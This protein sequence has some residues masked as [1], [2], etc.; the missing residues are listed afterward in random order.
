MHSKSHKGN[1]SFLSGADYFSLQCC[2]NCVCSIGALKGICLLRGASA[3]SSCILASHKP[4]C[5]NCSM[6]PAAPPWQR[7]QK[8]LGTSLFLFFPPTT[9]PR[10]DTPSWDFLI[11]IQKW[12]WTSCR[13]LQGVLRAGAPS[14]V[15]GKAKPARIILSP[16]TPARMSTQVC[17][18][19][20]MPVE[21]LGLSPRI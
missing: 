6:G 19:V 11:R 21:L 4:L 7:V 13:W 14:A 15:C 1:N 18:G 5:T 10:R 17:G 9:F 3:F 20:R 8:I 12:Q 2:K 16:D